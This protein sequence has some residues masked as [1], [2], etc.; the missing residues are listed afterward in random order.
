MSSVR[1][2]KYVLIGFAGLEWAGNNGESKASCYQL[3]H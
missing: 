2:N 3:R 1:R